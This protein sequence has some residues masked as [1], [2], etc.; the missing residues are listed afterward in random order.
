MRHPSKEIATAV[1]GVL[2]AFSF[3]SPAALLGPPA[4]I[5]QTVAPTTLSADIPAQPLAQALA[6]F[7]EQT[8][9]QLMYVSEI[10]ANHRSQAVPKGLPVGEALSRLLH[11]TGLRFEYLR[12]L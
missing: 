9:L 1:S 2:R 12:K 6:A 4:A 8:G 10:A 7:A 11:G 3:C 5:A